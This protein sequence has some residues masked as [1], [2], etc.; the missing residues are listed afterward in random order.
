LRRHG[1]TVIYVSHRLHEIFVLADRV[2][3]MRNGRVVT[4]QPTGQLDQPTLVSL[5]TGREQSGAT[6]AQP[7]T[8]QPRIKD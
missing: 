8:R 6:A 1:T 3:V 2:T 4:T 5:M 7:G